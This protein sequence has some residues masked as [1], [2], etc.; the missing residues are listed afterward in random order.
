MERSSVEW[1]AA[2]MFDD[3][4][5]GANP[6][7]KRASQRELGHMTSAYVITL[8]VILIY[9]GLAFVTPNKKRMHYPGVLR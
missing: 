6:T 9:R 7:K 5:T 4:D 2:G 8:N 3:G 1:T